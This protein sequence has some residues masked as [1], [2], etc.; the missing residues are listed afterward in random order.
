MTVTDLPPAPVADPCVAPPVGRT[1]MRPDGPQL[2]GAALAIVAALLLGLLLDLGPLGGLRHLRDHETGY[3]ELRESLAMGTTPI[4]QRAKDGRLVELG[5]PVALLEIPELGLREVVR[6]GT[7]GAVLEAG[8]GHRRDTPMPGQAGTSVLLGRQAGFGGPFG[9][10]GSLRAT[11][12]FTVTTGQGTHTYRVLDVR[13]AGDPVPAALKNGSGRLVL[14]TGDG[15]RYAPSGTLLVDADL[16]SEVKPA[17]ARP[18]TA[19]ALPPAERVMG[20]DG[21]AWIPLVLWGESLLLAAVALALAWS[22]WGRL[23]AWIVGVPVL[24]ALALSVADE[25]ARLLPN[26]I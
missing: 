10:L 5:T 25:V 26:L 18:L 16:V 17:N 24:S 14:V 1:R 4:G 2:V 12:T 19:D 21:D 6:E 3:A 7:T 15:P 22:R 9:A 13:R 11:E 8:P 23:Q 20:T